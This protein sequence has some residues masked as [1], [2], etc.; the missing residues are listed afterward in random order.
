M[1]HALLFQGPVQVEAATH[2]SEW[3]C[4]AGLLGVSSF[5]QDLAYMGFP[6]HPGFSAATAASELP[7]RRPSQMTTLSR[8]LPS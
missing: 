6:F 8:N 7:S 3:L 4:Q 1:A 5:P 2:A